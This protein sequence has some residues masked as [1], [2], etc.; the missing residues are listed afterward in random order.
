[1]SWGGK[2]VFQ[3]DFLLK[4]IFDGF[5]RL[6]EQVLG[7]CIF[8]EFVGKNFSPSAVRGVFVGFGRLRVPRTPLAKRKSPLGLSACL[9]SSFGLKTL[10]IIPGFAN[11]G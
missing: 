5:W 2:W 8:C 6:L 3:K 10:V 9:G 1:M 11:F 4:N 7:T